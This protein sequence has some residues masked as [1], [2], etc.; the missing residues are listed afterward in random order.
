MLLIMKLRSGKIIGNTIP[1]RKQ[2]NNFIN[3]NIIILL[4]TSIFIVNYYEKECYEL[5]DIFKKDPIYLVIMMCF[6][7]CPVHFV[8]AYIIVNN[9][10]LY[11]LSSDFIDNYGQNIYEKYNF[12]SNDFLKSTF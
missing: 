11:N 2:K 5:F 8:C 10:Y 7:V 12:S 6:L 9:E 3:S 4:L 1:D